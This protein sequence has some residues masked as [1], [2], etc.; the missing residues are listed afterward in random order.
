MMDIDTLGIEIRIRKLEWRIRFL[1]TILVVGFAFFAIS[2]AIPEE[3]GETSVR[4]HE[5]ILVD[6]AGAE[7]GELSMRDGVPGFY[8]KDDDGKD[9][10]ILIHN[11]ELT[12][13]YLLDGM[14]DVRI[15]AAQFSHGGGGFALHGPEGKG[16]AVLYLKK[17][18]SLRMFDPDGNVSAQFPPAEEK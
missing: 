7:R 5:F 9:R 1:I 14:G 2:M 11:E 10:V 4:A 12:A 3:P 18:G 13:L 15:G 17:S 6:S 16:G 8:L